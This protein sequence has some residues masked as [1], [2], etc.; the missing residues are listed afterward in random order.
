MHSYRREA[1]S[2]LAASNI[3]TVIMK[4]FSLDLQAALAWLA[5]RCAETVSRFLEN[6]NTYHPGAPKLM[7]ESGYTSTVLVNG[8]VVMMTRVMRANG[9]T[10]TM[11]YQSRPHVP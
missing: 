10:A 6:S 1:A 9:I 8:S 11:V 3:L 2:G 5:I 7:R 4:D